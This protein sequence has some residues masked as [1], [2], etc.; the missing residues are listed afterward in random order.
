[1]L[2]ILKRIIIYFRWL[3]SEKDDG[4]TERLLTLDYVDKEPEHRGIEIMQERDKVVDGEDNEKIEQNVEETNDTNG[5]GKDTAGEP[6]F[7][8]AD[9]GRKKDHLE[10]DSA[11]VEKNEKVND[12][13]T[14]AAKR[15]DVTAEES[16]AETKQ[17]G[18]DNTKQQNEVEDEK[19]ESTRKER[20]M[21]PMSNSGRKS[22]G[23]VE[24]KLTNADVSNEKE[25]S[26][27]EGN[28][29]EKDKQSL[30]EDV[31]EEKQT[32]KSKENVAENDNRSV[33]ENE[34]DDK[35]TA[36]NTA[37]TVHKEKSL[38]S[39]EGSVTYRVDKQND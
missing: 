24:E 38:V 10:D 13:D 20:S 3:H 11:N 12:A 37:E 28:F 17:D 35:K 8:V 27:S 22:A 16:G 26:K 31:T 36:D 19:V 39:R 5:V 29:A 1:M 33:N 7:D 4:S 21:T 6:V 15:D 9:D 18:T 30:N 32:S 34:P 2:Q 25:N 14:D 23:K